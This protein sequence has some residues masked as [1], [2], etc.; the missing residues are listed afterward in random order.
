MASETRMAA[1]ADE[2]MLVIE[3]EGRINR[4]DLIGAIVAAEAKW[5]NAEWKQMEAQMRTIAEMGVSR[6][7]EATWQLPV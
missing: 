1:I 2:V 7:P 3:R 4:D 5:S 6:N